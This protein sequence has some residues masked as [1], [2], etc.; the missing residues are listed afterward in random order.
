[1]YLK[2]L[3]I[4]LRFANALH[5]SQ[6][7]TVDLWAV[8]RHSRT[9]YPQAYCNKEFPLYQD[10]LMDQRNDVIEEALNVSANSSTFEVSEEELRQSAE[11]FIFLNMCPD[12]LF[13]TWQTFLKELFMKANSETI[14]LTL[15]RILRKKDFGVAKQIFRKFSS[16]LALEYQDL[17]NF[18]SVG[19]FDNKG[20]LMQI[21]NHISF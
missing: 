8:I 10:Y 9:S 4:F 3:K 20:R 14:L 7:S 5:S 18:I 13:I 12:E 21:N 19:K 6:M 17:G 1:M 11:M 2:I 16:M 15:N